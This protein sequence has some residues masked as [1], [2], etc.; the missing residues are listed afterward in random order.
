LT[1]FHHVRGF[2]ERDV[3]LGFFGGVIPMLLFLL[4]IG[5][6]VWAILRAGGRGPVAVQT[7]PPFAPVAP[8]DSPW[9]RSA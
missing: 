8:R 1:A 7:S 6:A 9:R 2:A 4:L 3:G 5:V